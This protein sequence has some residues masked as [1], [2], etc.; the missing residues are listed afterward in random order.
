MQKEFIE[1]AALELRTPIQPILGFTE[2]LKN[3]ITDK[4]QIDLLEII[5]RNTRR[6]KKLSESIL[7]LS[8]I[9]NNL[10]SMH[11]DQFNK[12]ELIQNLIINYKNE[13][14]E[15]DLID[16]YYNDFIKKWTF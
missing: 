15:F 9:E 10:L 1:I 14:I 2:Y 3:R 16:P 11:K 4:G 13:N 12:K 6:L 5:D 8:K 7:E